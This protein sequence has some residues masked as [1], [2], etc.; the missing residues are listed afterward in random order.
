MCHSQT[1]VGYENDHTSS[2]LLDTSKVS[3]KKPVNPKKVTKSSVSEGKNLNKGK[4]DKKT[5]TLKM[6]PKVIFKPHHRNKQGRTAMQSS[7]YKK[8]VDKKNDVTRKELDIL[9]AMWENDRD[10]MTEDQ[11]QNR[12]KL[13]RTISARESRLSKKQDE[14]LYVE[15]I[16]N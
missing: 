5:K 14:T 4:P 12:F 11:K 2:T 7:D 3:K 10:N 9:E 13:Q 16:R 1:P 8:T 15:I 6:T